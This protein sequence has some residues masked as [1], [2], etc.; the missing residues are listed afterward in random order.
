MR[1]L[2][3]RLFA[4]AFGSLTPWVERR[5]G[6]ARRLQMVV[7]IGTLLV[8]SGNAAW[9]QAV[10]CRQLQDQAERAYFQAD[11]QQTIDLLDPC[12]NGTAKDEVTV[13]VYRLAAFAHLGAGDTDAARLVVEDLLD[14][15]PRYTPNPDDDRPDYVALVEDVKTSRQPPAEE[16]TSSGDRR[17]VRWAI[18]SVVVVAT[19]A[20]ISVVTGGGG[21]D[22]DDD[23][24]FDDVDD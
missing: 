14:G 22:G 19:A 5:T 18:A 6:G 20:I 13:Q 16:A 9:A 1:D 7:I 12:L 4:S 15:H 11:F 3:A 2:T 8:I 10:D 24:D 17:W 23:D 21:G